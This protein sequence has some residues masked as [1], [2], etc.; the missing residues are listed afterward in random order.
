MQEVEGIEKVEHLPLSN[1]QAFE[2]ARCTC[3]RAVD[4]ATAEQAE[5]AREHPILCFSCLE[6]RTEARLKAKVRARAAA[7]ARR[8]PGLLQQSAENLRGW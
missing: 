1:R 5:Y 4:R 8:I 2:E 3:G 7:A 6:A